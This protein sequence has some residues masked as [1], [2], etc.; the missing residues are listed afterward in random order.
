MSDLTLLEKIAARQA[1]IEEKL[2][3]LLSLTGRPTDPAPPLDQQD[4]INLARVDRAAA[5]KAAKA[6]F[7]ATSRQN[8]KTR[9]AC[10]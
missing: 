8:G 1:V 2:D 9:E 4:L 5:I 6:R 3:V 10:S 7:R